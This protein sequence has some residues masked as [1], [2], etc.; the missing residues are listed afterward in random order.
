MIEETEGWDYTADSPKSYLLHNIQGL[1]FK[2][3]YMDKPTTI[4]IVN[5]TN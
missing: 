1:L 4:V 3:K 2:V 5:K